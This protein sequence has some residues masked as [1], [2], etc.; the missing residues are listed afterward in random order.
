M[1]TIEQTEQTVQ[2]NF[3]ILDTTIHSYVLDTSKLD[4]AKEYN[5]MCKKLQ[6][7]GLKKSKTL[8]F[9]YKVPWMQIKSESF[10]CR[11][12]TKWL[13]D[14]QW[15]ASEPNFRLWDWD[16]KISDYAQHLKIG[17]YIEQ[18]PAMIEIRK[19]VLKCRY[20]GAHY[21]VA[22]SFCNACLGNEYL[23]IDNLHL[24][25]LTPI[26]DLG[27][28]IQPLEGDELETL[29]VAFHA[30]QIHGTTKRDKKRIHETRQKVVREFATEIHAATTK[31][32]GFLW[33]LDRGLNTANLIY[34]P[35]KNQFSLGWRN[36]ITSP[37]LL[38]YWRDQTKDFP[39][40]L[41]IKTSK[42]Q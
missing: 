40:P 27:K 7:Q 32:D 42:N 12:E 9:Q 35:H 3:P 4:Q 11:L 10:P 38:A 24:L 26:C 16:E 5:Y 20:C 2:T 23:T 19:T 39:F 31:H 17:Y 36:P 21:R 18:T 25:R 13:F 28:P 22:Q 8:A 34:Y 33:F 41:E 1:N 37:E 6:A 29:K 14:N 15:N 30:A